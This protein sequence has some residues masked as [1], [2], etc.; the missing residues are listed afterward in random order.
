MKAVAKKSMLMN[1]CNACKK[2]VLFYDML[3]YL[4]GKSMTIATIAILLHL[5]HDP[6]KD[7]SPTPYT[8]SRLNAPILEI[9]T[10]SHSV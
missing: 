6:Q 8:Q 10:N 5:W 9:D 3:L 4:N 1:F 2:S 7:S